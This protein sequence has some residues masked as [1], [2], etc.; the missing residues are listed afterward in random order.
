ML[1]YFIILSGISK[2]ISRSAVEGAQIMDFKLLKRSRTCFATCLFMLP[3]DIPQ[4]F[5]EYSIN[6]WCIIYYC[7]FALMYTIIKDYSFT[8]IFLKHVFIV[9]GRLIVKKLW[10]IS[11]LYYSCPLDLLKFLAHSLQKWFCLRVLRVIV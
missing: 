10:F 1:Q 6:E 7:T 11:M 3:L 9:A 8:E 4:K 5:T 2:V